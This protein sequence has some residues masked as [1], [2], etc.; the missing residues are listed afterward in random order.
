MS[1]SF[2]GQEYATAGKFKRKA[3][4]QDTLAPLDERARSSTIVQPANQD[5]CRA[6]RLLE[7][8]REVA[9]SA[10]HMAYEAS[11]LA[12]AYFTRLLLRRRN[13]RLANQELEP[14]PADM[15]Q[16]YYVCLAMCKHGVREATLT[17]AWE[18]FPGLQETANQL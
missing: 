6:D 17:Q 4:D 2:Y 5:K 16:F 9:D 12:N 18:L 11:L 14:L 13:L 8:I 1:T 15:E 7:L 10:S 3:R